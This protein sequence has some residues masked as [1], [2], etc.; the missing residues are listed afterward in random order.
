MVP[1]F[2]L[3]V[4]PDISRAA[5]NVDAATSAAVAA[6]VSSTAPPPDQ[7]TKPSA[8]ISQEAAEISA[9]NQRIAVMAA[10]LAE[11]EMQ[12]KIKAKESELAKGMSADSGM[13]RIED[14]VIPSVS[15][16]SGIDNKIWAVV[17]VRGGTQTVRVGDVAAGWRVTNIKSDSVTV[18][19]M[20]RKLIL[21]FG[22][23]LVQMP[24]N[25]DAPGAIATPHPMGGI[26][27]YP[28]R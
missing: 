28:G 24:A 12:A 8:K 25:N 23:N 10:R 7:P 13:P 19:K 9:I 5:D 4:V 26:P 18:E 21:S 11:L 6:I 27:G 16:I 1:T 20:G 3:L 17:N 15:E 22:S 2:A 14:N